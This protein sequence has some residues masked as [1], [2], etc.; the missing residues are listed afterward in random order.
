LFREER[1]NMKYHT[2]I[3]TKTVRMAY[4]I[5]MVFSFASCAEYHLPDGAEEPGKRHTGRVLVTINAEA[6][7][8]LPFESL[9][10]RTMLPETGGI[11]YVLAFTRS[12]ETSPAVT[13]TVAGTSLLV[14][15][16]P[17]DYTL[18]VTGFQRYGAPDAVDM[19]EGSAPLTV[20][21]D[22]VTP[23]SVVMSVKSKTSAVFSYSV[24]LPEGMA[25][26]IGSIRIEPLSGGTE[27]APINLGA[28]LSGSKTLSTGHYRITLE[29][30][31][32]LAGQGKTYGKTSVAYIGDGLVTPAAYTLTAED[33]INVNV[34]SVQNSA[35]LVS[36]HT[37]IK[38]SSD[39][40]FFILVGAGF[41]RG[42]LAF[43]DAGFS[44]KTI[45]LRSLGSA[46]H[47]ITLSS[48]G[49]FLTL[50]GPSVTGLTFV[51]NNI[52]LKGKDK[53]SAPLIAVDGNTL[54]LQSGAVIKDN[55]INPQTVLTSAAGGGVFVSGGVL[56][57]SGGTISN[58]K[59]NVVGQKPSLSAYAYGGGVALYNSTFRMNGGTISG[60]MARAASVD[61]DD[62][63][64]YS[65]SYGGGVYADGTSAVYISG[66]LITGNNAETFSEALGATFLHAAGA[67]SYGGGVYVKSGNLENT[68]G[69]VT[70][71]TVTADARCSNGPT[72]IATGSDIHE[73]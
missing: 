10:P 18:A 60:N 56:E 4:C 69:S 49:T 27:P 33:F 54:I 19:S 11:T 63:G 34:Y 29:L 46:V 12:G 32:D 48:N 62:N 70:G 41:S 2:L 37:Q 35:D 57:M 6:D 8:I 42:P 47:E 68:G 36:A 14:D 9:S 13:E 40:K 23:V 51:L 65:S 5:L 39:D 20:T 25:L 61:W 21:S 3:S 30:L 58:N 16:E 26:H 7:P 22:T 45:T 43:T 50:G 59:I 38:N 72:R 64:C 55:Y 67:V 28:A 31:G 44:D 52:S 15:L 53:N 73:Y 66:G 71:N 17:G 24:N 1:R